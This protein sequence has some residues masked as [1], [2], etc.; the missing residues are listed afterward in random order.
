MKNSRLV[1]RLQRLS[2]LGHD[3]QGEFFATSFSST[4]RPPRCKIPGLKGVHHQIPGRLIQ[5]HFVKLNEMRI[6]AHSILQ[7]AEQGEFTPQRASFLFRIA[8]LEDAANFQFIMHAGP[9][10]AR[11]SL[12]KL[13]GQAPLSAWY[14]SA[15]RRLPRLTRD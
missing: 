4:S 5:R 1:G 3:F 8:E 10:L 15:N 7:Q 6:S 9:D 13:A 11:A 12:A 14:D 2:R